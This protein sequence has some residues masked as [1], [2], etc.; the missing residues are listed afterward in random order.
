M[1]S[2]I[3]STELRELV[4]IV[5][6]RFVHSTVSKVWVFPLFREFEIFHESASERQ[7]ERVHFSGAFPPESVEEGKNWANPTHQDSQKQVGDSEK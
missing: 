6:K 4:F 5:V 3:A 2:A 1:F 7:R